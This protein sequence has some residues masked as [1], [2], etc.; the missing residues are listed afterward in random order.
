MPI[1]GERS[2]LV[3]IPDA[4][5]PRQK[6]CLQAIRYSLE[7]VE[8]SFGRLQRALDELSRS[9][10][11]SHALH[12]AALLDAWSLV[13]S[14]Y[15]LRALIRKM[16]RYRERAPSKQIF[17]RE[18]RGVSELRHAWQHLSD[19]MDERIA[20][21]LPVLGRLA[22]VSPLDRSQSLYVL[23]TYI[24]GQAPDAGGPAPVVEIS[25]GDGDG[26]P[27]IALIAAEVCVSLTRVYRVFAAGTN[28]RAA[29]RAEI[30]RSTEHDE[31]HNR[32]HGC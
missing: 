11:R 20:Q 21:R 1:L 6:R 13:D 5:E 31:R 4:L 8:T 23:G 10:T 14:V 17:L 32:V 15:R 28:V 7:F 27:E 2:A 19:E 30:C 16:P 18:T 12:A 9:R 25:D 26:L 29:A 24:T 22:W 3:Y